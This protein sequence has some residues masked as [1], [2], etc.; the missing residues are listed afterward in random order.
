M[1]GKW[2]GICVCFFIVCKKDGG[3]GVIDR[4]LFFVI[5]KLEYRT[6]FS[7]EHMS[8]TVVVMTVS[9]FNIFC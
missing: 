6:C 1:I 7:V 9:C 2:S 4:F 5:K 8:D 3:K